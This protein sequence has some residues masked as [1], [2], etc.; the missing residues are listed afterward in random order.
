M[1]KNN[2]DYGKTLANHAREVEDRL[3]DALHASLIARFVDKR[4]SKLLKGIGA[5]AYMSATIK[6]NGDVF[7]DDHLIGQLYGLTFKPDVSGSG[8]EAKALDAAAAK[9]VAP[10]I[11][12]R[13][14]SLCGGAHNIFTLSESGEI[15]WGGMIV[16]R[17]APS[18]SVFTPDAE[19]IAS[20]FANSNLR[21]LASDRM[22]EYLRAEVTAHLGPLKALRDFKDQEDRKSVV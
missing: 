1:P 21:N 3:S 15:L 18:G 8:L 14:T 17:I 4:T 20:D 7:V 16:G 9:A 6:D 19:V 5:D 10:E 12:R 13:L 22:R 2:L 11:D